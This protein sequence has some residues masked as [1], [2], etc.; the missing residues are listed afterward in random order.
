MTESESL[1]SRIQ[2][3]SDA[4]IS[5]ALIAADYTPIFE[6]LCERLK[7]I[8]IPISHV[9]SATTT[10]HPLA[11][12]LSM[13]WRSGVG[14]R[15]HYFVHGPE[16]WRRWEDSPLARMATDRQTFVRFNGLGL[17]EAASVFPVLD[18]LVEDG[19]CDYVGMLLTFAPTDVAFEKSDGLVVSFATDSEGGFSDQHI[20][21]LRALMPRFGLVAKLAN[22]E[23]LLINVLDAY[24][25][26]D[27]GA[28]VRDGQIALGAGE[29]TNAVIWFCD[30]RDSVALA[31]RLGHQGFMDLLT[32][33]FSALCEAIVAHNGQILR[34]IGDAALAIFP[35][36]AEDEGGDQAKKNA[37]LAVQ[38]AVARSR[39]INERR[40][41]DGLVPFEYGIGLHV[42]DILYGNIGI[43]SRV[44]FSVIGPA[45]N[46][47][48]RIEG[49]CKET[50][51]VILVSE[52]FRGGMGGVWRE[53]GSFD[54]RG[55]S[56]VTLFAP[57][58]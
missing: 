55:G 30:L 11:Q 32:D 22:R 40:T 15:K 8:G 39:E 35:I 9:E 6:S 20:G 37:L 42:G 50:G 41:G 49:L 48:A 52:A 3:L 28:R 5:E 25:G 4:I 57:S 26:P 51:E 54:L 14:V 44:E 45:A 16:G 17:E 13:T 31:E 21:A 12:G 10:L 34:F 46:A 36:E 38:D 19:V 58:I 2:V 7:L 43:P 1:E 24:L 27:A 29:V 53:L 23:G 47:A 18:N 33:Y 56:S